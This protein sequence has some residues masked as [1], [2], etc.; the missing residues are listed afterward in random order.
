M[1][2]A[3]KTNTDA[4]QTEIETVDSTDPATSV[5]GDLVLAKAYE[6]LNATSKS[7]P[8]VDIT[9]EF[10]EANPNLGEEGL[11]NLSY[12]GNWYEEEDQL[13]GDYSLQIEQEWLSMVWTSV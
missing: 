12:T 7:N 11:L 9:V 13:Y 5:T 6:E 4:S 8:L 3:E 1:N 2:E 10:L